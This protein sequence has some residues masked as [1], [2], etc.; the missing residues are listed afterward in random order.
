M[1]DVPF[2][3]NRPVPLIDPV[4]QLKGPLTVTLPLPPSTP[5][6]RVR[7]GNVV[8]EF[9]ASV[10]PFRRLTP[11]GRLKVVPVALTVPLLIRRSPAP[12]MFEPAASVRLSVK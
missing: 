8:A 1:L 7:F 2:V 3:V 4:A 12:V 9:I 5:F 6:E 11:R 10:A